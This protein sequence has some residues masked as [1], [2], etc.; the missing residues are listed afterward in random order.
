MLQQQS[1]EMISL[2]DPNRN[3]RSNIT[4]CNHNK[5]GALVFQNVTSY[6]Q[7]AIFLKGQ[8]I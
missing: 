3:L 7:V 2:W 6:R 1:N 8:I 5:I 4:I